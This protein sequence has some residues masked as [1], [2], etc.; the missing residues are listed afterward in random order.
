MTRQSG[1]AAREIACSQFMDPIAKTLRV[2]DVSPDFFW[3]STGQKPFT[4]FLHDFLPGTIPPDLE[5][6]AP[7]RCAI[8][9]FNR[10][11]IGT[12]KFNPP[13]VM[14][15][16]RPRLHQLGTRCRQIDCGRPLI[17][18]LK[19]RAKLFHA[20]PAAY[21]REKVIARD[22]VFFFL[23]ARNL[24]QDLAVRGFTNWNS[25][26]ESPG[27]VGARRFQCIHKTLHCKTVIER[28]PKLLLLAVIEASVAS[29]RLQTE[30][31]QIYFQ[32]HLRGHW[33]V[34]ALAL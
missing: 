20:V 1:L 30:L 28:G 14:Q 2:D 16:N 18:F 29:E 11:P 17:L 33:S 26:D 31:R 12:D 13:P 7:A 15:S 27:S 10:Q 19:F 23:Q 6:I 4:I 8:D 3:L 24:K 5:R 9:A 22:S 32:R 34:Q 25:S 21:C